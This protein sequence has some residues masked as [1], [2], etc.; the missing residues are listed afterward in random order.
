MNHWYTAHY[1][2][3]DS[4]WHFLESNQTAIEVPADWSWWWFTVYIAVLPPH[5]LLERNYF[6]WIKVDSSCLMIYHTWLIQFF[7]SIWYIWEVLCP[8]ISFHVYTIWI[9]GMDAWIWNLSNCLQN[10]VNLNDQKTKIY[11]LLKLKRI[12]PHYQW[13]GTSIKDIWFFLIYLCT[14]SY[15]LWHI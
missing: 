2:W 4:H 14:T 8:Y 1:I 12:Q 7:L 5:L 13:K 11:D 10:Q 3:L 6:R 9:Y 15:Y